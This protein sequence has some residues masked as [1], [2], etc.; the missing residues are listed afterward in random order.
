MEKSQFSKEYR[1]FLRQLQAARLEAG[2]T[3]QQVAE[4]LG[5]TQSSVSKVERGER[6]ID[7]VELRAFCE[8]VGI[9]FPTFA[10]RLHQAILANEKKS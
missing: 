8:A 4:R 7:V 1:V 9:S 3:Q 2:V 5:V 6:R 10:T